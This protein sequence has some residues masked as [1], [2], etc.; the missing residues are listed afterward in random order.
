[1]G[2]KMK[3]NEKQI[4]EISSIMKLEFSKEETDKLLEETNKTLSMLQTLGEVDTEGVEGTFYGTVNHEMNFRKDEAIRNEK[5]VDAL[6][7]N[8]P[9]SVDHLIQ[10]P[11]ILDEGEGGA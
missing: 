5:E 11:A 8:T 2:E 1:M 4:Q 9:T 10:V 7:E 6:L 3:V